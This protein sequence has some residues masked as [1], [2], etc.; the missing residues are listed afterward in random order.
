MKRF[1]HI[2]LLLPLLGFTWDI[3]NEDEP[4]RP[5]WATP[6]TQKWD[7]PNKPYEDV[8]IDQPD[9][10]WYDD[11]RTYPI[12]AEW[13][14]TV[15]RRFQDLI[16]AEEMT[17]KQILRARTWDRSPLRLNT[18]WIDSKS[19]KDQG[20]IFASVPEFNQF[21]VFKLDPPNGTIHQNMQGKAKIFNLDDNAQYRIIV[22]DARD[23]VATGGTASADKYIRIIVLQHSSGFHEEGGGRFYADDYRNIYSG[24]VEGGNNSF[25]LGIDTFGHQIWWHQGYGDFGG[26]GVY[27]DVYLDKSKN[28]F[29]IVHYEPWFDDDPGDNQW[30]TVNASIN[31]VDHFSGVSIASKRDENPQG[32]DILTSIT[33]PSGNSGYVV[34]RHYGLTNEGQLRRMDDDLNYVP[35]GSGTTPTV[36]Q[37][38]W[39]RI[40]VD[41]SA[42]YVTAG[43]NQDDHLTQDRTAPGT[44]VAAVPSSMS[45]SAYPPSQALDNNDSNMWYYV[46][47]EEERDASG[48]PRIKIDFGAGNAYAVYSGT[49]IPVENTSGNTGYIV[50]GSNNDST[51]DFLKGS[52]AGGGPAFSSDWNNATAYRYIRIEFVQV[53]QGN[54]PDLG[55]DGKPASCNDPV[56]YREYWIN[57]LELYAYVAGDYSQHAAIA[58]Y[59]GDSGGNEGVTIFEVENTGVSRF[60]SVALGTKDSDYRVVGHDDDGIY[61]ARIDALSGATVWEK[62]FPAGTTGWSIEPALENGGHIISGDYRNPTT[63]RQQMYLLK[64]S[65]SGDEE[66]SQYF[67]PGTLFQSGARHAIETDD[68]GYLAS[69]YAQADGDNRKIYLIKTNRHGESCSAGVPCE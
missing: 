64:I 67:N 43:Y 66:W 33:R 54:G 62:S 29:I 25:M 31:I 42:D 5:V 12:P 49:I 63:G 69:G 50:H 15:R 7:Q 16:R 30:K 57:E 8:E 17:E 22:F 24:F 34:T 19:D 20:Y 23:V 21:T 10:G 44:S 36:S 53:Y 52:I 60:Q 48:G 28:H 65:D 56:N 61:V 1:L 2:I 39:K 38:W 13:P 46:Q 32:L 59:E 6:Q 26:P 4:E 45:C 27:N 55:C 68:R 3:N 11:P 18:K 14:E 40:I 35:W 58:K 41:L 37:V 9:A 47:C 51:W